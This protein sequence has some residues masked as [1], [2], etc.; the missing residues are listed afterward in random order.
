MSREPTFL[1][2]PFFLLTK[3]ED[4]WIAKKTL[5]NSRLSI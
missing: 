2:Q 3:L 5:G 4:E 1:R